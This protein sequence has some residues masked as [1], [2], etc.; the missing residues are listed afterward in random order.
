MQG[1]ELRENCCLYFI[2]QF[3]F[4]FEWRMEIR[5]LNVNNKEKKLNQWFSVIFR[6]IATNCFNCELRFA[7]TIT[8]YLRIFLYLKLLSKFNFTYKCYAKSW[9]RLN[10]NVI[11]F[12]LEIII[13]FFFFPIFSIL[14]SLIE[15]QSPLYIII[16]RSNEFFSSYLL[17]ILLSISEAQLLASRKL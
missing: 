8:F 3:F 11:Y 1:K 14:I 7:I 6:M 15:N 9:I 4:F 17:G 12:K 10:W 5:E 13:F 16:Y 2:V